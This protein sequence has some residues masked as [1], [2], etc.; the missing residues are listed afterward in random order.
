MYNHVA[1]TTWW[2]ETLNSNEALEKKWLTEN[3]SL[4]HNSSTIKYCN[5]KCHLFMKTS[6]GTSIQWVIFHCQ[7]GES[8]PRSA[9]SISIFAWQDRPKNTGDFWEKTLLFPNGGSHC[10][11]SFHKWG[12]PRLSSI[13]IGFSL[14]PP[15][16]IPLS[17]A[18]TMATMASGEHRENHYKQR[19]KSI[20]KHIPKMHQDAIN[21]DWWWLMMSN[22]FN[23]GFNIEPPK[24]ILEYS[25]GLTGYGQFLGYSIWYFTGTI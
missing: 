14:I 7:G 13:R 22:G 21:D 9:R 25:F 18:W 6:I 19:P 4:L 11:E 2:K 24:R 23:D 3:H 5:G 15:A 20:N 8:Q 12:Y 10:S 17:M 1:F 16:G